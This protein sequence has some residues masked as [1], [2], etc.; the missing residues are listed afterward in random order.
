MKLIPL[1]RKGCGELVLEPDNREE[2]AH[3]P[4]RLDTAGRF[5]GGLAFKTRRAIR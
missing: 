2:P 5:G 1:Q 3:K 4:K